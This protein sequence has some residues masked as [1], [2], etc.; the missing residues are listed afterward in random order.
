V[1]IVPD[2]GA[3]ASVESALSGDFVGSLFSSLAQT[4]IQITMPKFTIQGRTISLKDELSKLGMADAFTPSAN[5]SKMTSQ[6]ALFI[7]GVL[8][9][10]FV[11]VDESG[12]E[13]AAAT[14][15]VARTTSVLLPDKTV[16]VDRP[17]FFVVRDI[18][19]GT[20]LFAGRELDPQ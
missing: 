18:P 20:V 17:F 10:A 3:F 19:T 1:L 7:D 6:G 8:H 4:S 14:A 2:E 5:F 12:T 16:T 15:V 11:K 9:Q 13:A